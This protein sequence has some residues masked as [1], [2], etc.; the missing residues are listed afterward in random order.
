MRQVRV[1]GERFLTN[2]T[3]RYKAPGT[4]SGPVRGVPASRSRVWHSASQPRVLSAAKEQTNPAIKFFSNE[5]PCG[6][7]SSP[8]QRPA[9][10]LISAWATE[11]GMRLPRGLVREKCAGKNVKKNKTKQIYFSA[12]ISYVPSLRD[13]KLNLWLKT[14][15]MILSFY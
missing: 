3:A 13:K 14:Q 1:K 10:P 6:I 5:A 4:L 8:R 15:N 9:Q 11:G 12:R 2:I 7:N